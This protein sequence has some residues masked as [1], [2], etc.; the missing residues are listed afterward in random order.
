MADPDTDE[1]LGSLAL[2]DL[3]PGREAEVGYWTHPDARGTRRDD[4]GVRAGCG[5]RFT[6]A[7]EGGLGL[8]RVQISAADGNAASR[9][10]IEAMRLRLTAAGSG[11]RC[12][13]ATAAWST[14]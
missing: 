14:R 10:V 7:E 2:F 1:L 5:T 12:G 3:K 4:R 8:R 6:P 11:G 13:C 9:H